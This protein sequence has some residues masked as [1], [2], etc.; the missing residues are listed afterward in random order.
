MRKFTTFCE[1]Y[2]VPDPFPVTEFLLCSFA[3]AMAD[4]GLAPQTVKSYLAAIRN[5]QLSLGLPDPREQSSLPVL[6][7]V[8]AGI[9]RSRL[10]RSQP[11]RVRLPVTAVLLRRI[12]EELERSAHPERRVLWAVCGTA[13]FG[14]FRLGEL[15]RSSPSDFNPRLHL[16]WGDMAVDNSLEPRMLR[17]RLR[18]SKT[19]QFGRGVDVVL[20]KTGCDLCPVAAVLSY[21]STR[22]N[23]QGPFF[24]KST[25]RPL[26]KQEFITE[27]RRVLAALGSPTTNMPATAF[28]SEQR[29]QQP[30]RAWRTPPS[31]SWVSGRVRRSSATSGPLTNDW[32]PSPPPLHPR[33]V[34]SQ[35]RRSE[36]C[37]WNLVVYA[38]AHLSL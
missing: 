24:L 29:H 4:D 21:V 27:I 5:T 15:L 30:W 35:H 33:A 19:D 6:K 38:C 28:E 14:F 23:Q 7:R 3:A 13:F 11:S 10:G 8:L 36:P 34:R 22:G 26:L 1:R 2:H 32:R 17:F 37:M 16:S 31:S 20:G 25:N 9:S 12:R 18:Q